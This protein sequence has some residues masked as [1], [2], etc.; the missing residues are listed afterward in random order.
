VIVRDALPGEL[1][2]VGEIRVTA[3][4][5][6]GFLSPG[7]GYAPVLR[8]LGSD[9]DGTVLVAV[10]GGKIIG[11]V[12]LRSGGQVVAGPGEAEIR[13]LA[14]APAGQG[15]GTGSALLRAVIERAARDGVRNLLL[16]TQPE[17]LAAQRLYERAGF[18]RLPGRDWSPVPGLTL[19]AYELPLG[20]GVLG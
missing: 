20:S 16:L 1:A 6:A 18:H 3:Y 11:T 15:R 14:V 5:D 4:T 17:M 12:M 10:D 7:S 19:L 2:E 8:E 13:A 9:G